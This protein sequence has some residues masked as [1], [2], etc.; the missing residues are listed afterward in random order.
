MVGFNSLKS[1]T[2]S[3]IDLR[4]DDNASNIWSQAGNIP[5]SKL[6]PHC[7]ATFTRTTQSNRHLR[8]REYFFL[9]CEDNWLTALDR[10]E[11]TTTLVWCESL[12]SA[13]VGSSWLCR[14]VKLRS[15]Q[16]IFSLD[17]KVLAATCKSHPYHLISPIPIHS[18][19]S[20]S[21]ST[22]RTRR[23]SCK[24]CTDSKV[25]CDLEHPCLKCTTRGKECIYST[26]TSPSNTTGASDRGER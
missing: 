3:F 1:S 6:C 25:Q 11:W 19:S 9:Y 8:T 22:S 26:L 17:T 18:V 2:P 4:K 5:K 24:V 23:K 10:Y 16:A 12:F 21:L 14:L 13:L 15:L 7:D 20:S